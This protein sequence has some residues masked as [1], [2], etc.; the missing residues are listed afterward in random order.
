MHES[1]FSLLALVV[2]VAASGHTLAQDNCANAVAVITGS[3]GP[4]TNVGATTSTPG[5]P[6]GAAANDVWFSYVATATGP[7][8]ASTCGSSL[9]TTLEVFNGSGGCA[10]MVSLGCNDDTCGL[11]SSVTISAT[12]GTTYFLRVGGFSGAS[13]TFSLSI[14]R[15]ATVVAQGTGCVGRFTSFYELL[16]NTGFDLSGQRLTL[17]N[18]ASGYT[19][20]LAPGA[21]NAIGSLGAATQLALTDDSQVVAG[22]LGVT[23]GSNCWIARAPGNVSA[24]S[25]TVAQMLGNPATGFYSWKDLNPAA[26]GSG[27]V[28]YEEAGAQAQIT[29][30][31]V[32]AYNTTTPYTVQFN[33]N[34]TT[35]NVTI[36]WGSVG[37]NGSNWIVGYSPG[38]PSLDRG[39]IDLSLAGTVLGAASDLAPLVLTTTAVPSQGVGPGTFQ[40]TTSSIPGSAIAHVGIIGL[41]NPNLSLG[42]SLGALECFQY[43]SGD[44]LVGP[45]VPTPSLTWTAFNLPALPPVFAGFTFYAQA[46]VL[47][48]QLNGALGLGTLT[49]NGLMATVGL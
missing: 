49:S 8:T 19:G 7:V 45:A 11:Q 14:G 27:Q 48:T 35:G 47:G 1:R 24:Y 39:S 17:N 40:V 3:N 41:N 18:T 20:T 29:Y 25:L 13:G 4:F 21:V 26:A 22:T 34:T 46:A 33:I 9:D 36:T 10:A 38:G 32:Y 5:W 15:P 42:A 28:H 43:A 23:V 37:S 6:C 44:V 31:G 2:A 30:A 16:T 12:V